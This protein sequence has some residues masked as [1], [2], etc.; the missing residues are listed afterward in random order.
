MK[1]K[2]ERIAVEEKEKERAEA[3]QHTKQNTTQHNEEVQPVCCTMRWNK[4]CN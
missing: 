2:I 1:L 3:E 4:R